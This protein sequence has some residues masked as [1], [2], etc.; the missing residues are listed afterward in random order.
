VCGDLLFR[1]LRA[2]GIA[3]G[4]EISTGQDDIRTAEDPI[5]VDF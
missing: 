4:N 1:Q 3:N 5:A 2:T